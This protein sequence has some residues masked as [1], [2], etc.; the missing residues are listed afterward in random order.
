MHQPPRGVRVRDGNVGKP[1]GE[2][3]PVGLGKPPPG[4]EGDGDA[5]GEA[6]GEA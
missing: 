5:D 3:V 1:V 2:P 6:V 4:G